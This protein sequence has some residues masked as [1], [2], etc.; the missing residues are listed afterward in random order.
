MVRKCALLAVAVATVVSFGVGKARAASEDEVKALFAKFIAAQNAHDIN[1]VRDILQDSPQFLWIT[2]GVALWG[3]DA[4]LKRY[5]ENY[6]GTWRLEPKFDEVQ[7]TEIAPGVV[8]VFAPSVFTI[9]PA[10]Q[11]AQPRR[12]L[13][14][15][16]YVKTAEGWRLSTLLPFPTP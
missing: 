7:V 15:Q 4:A 13:L 2:R 9:A 12:F 6:Q 16:V 11:D 1:A 8:R 5:E 10:G 3:R 14:T